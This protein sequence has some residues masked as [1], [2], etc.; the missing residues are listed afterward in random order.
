MFLTIFGFGF[1]FGYTV[2]FNCINLLT[3]GQESVDG[4]KL[5]NWSKSRRKKEIKPRKKKE[6]KSFI[7][8]SAIRLY[9]YLEV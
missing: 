5:K 6:T 9:I 3:Q 7:L 2:N 8:I 4:V 1:K